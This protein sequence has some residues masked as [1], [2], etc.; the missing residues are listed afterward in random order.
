LVVR[1][2][3][4]VLAILVVCQVLDAGLRH[5]K[6]RRSNLDDLALAVESEAAAYR[7]V[8]LG[9]SITREAR[10]FW[11]GRGR[12]DA[13]D[14]AT[15]SWTG[16]AAEVFLL[17]R[18]LRHHPAPRLVVYAVAPDDLQTSVSA[19]VVRYHDWRVYD[20]PEERAFLRRFVPGI[21]ARDWLPAA[22]DVQERIVE[23]LLSL[24]ARGAPSMPAGFRAPDPLVQPDV[25]DADRSAW[26]SA[27]RRMG[28]ALVVGALQEAALLRICRLSESF[29]FRFA[30]VWAPVPPVVLQA[31]RQNG[32]FERL[33]ARVRALLGTG[34]H[35]A[36]P[37]DMNTVR[38][39]TSFDR[40]ALHLR[41]DAWEE[42]YAADLAAYIEALSGPPAMASI[43]GQAGK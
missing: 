39:Y 28:R 40:D 42:R 18:Y 31:W 25:L 9:D 33:N 16:A 24:A 36:A 21:D 7:V 14:L 22:F 32:Q 34:C 12:T 23:P 20:R 37:F 27:Q 15:I 26:A 43:V 11:L 35:A 38:R 5:V 41:S 3:V 8:V 19:R 6:L 17:E 4:A 1:V 30:L 13:V 10:R 29:G 2:P